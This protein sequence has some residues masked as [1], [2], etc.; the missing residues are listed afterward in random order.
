MVH[1]V[2]RAVLKLQICFLIEILS[3]GVERMSKYQE[4]NIEILQRF[5]HLWQDAYHVAGQILL[6]AL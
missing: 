1:V 5:L 4:P 6:Y 2:Y 3:T